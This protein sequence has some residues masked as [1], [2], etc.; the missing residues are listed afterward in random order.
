[1]KHIFRRIEDGVMIVYDDKNPKEKKHIDDLKKRK[2]FELI[3]TAESSP[4]PKAFKTVPITE[5]TLECAIHG[6][7]F[8]N[9]TELMKHKKSWAKKK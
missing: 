4:A 2:G 3:S 5:D 8:E 1:M 9:E 7:V 6:E